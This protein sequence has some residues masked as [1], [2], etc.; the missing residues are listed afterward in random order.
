MNL[1]LIRLVSFVFIL[2]IVFV[3]SSFGTLDSE[4]VLKDRQKFNKLK[5]TTQNIYKVTMRSGVAFRL[6]TALGYVSTIDLPERA[7]KVY[8]GD[9]ELYK[10]EV[11]ERQVLVKPITDEEDARTNLIIVTESGRL[12]FDVSVGSP[13]TADFVLDFRLPIDD[14]Y[15]VR[16][17]FDE[18]VQEKVL[19]LESSYQEQKKELDKKAE[20][21]S[22]QKLKERVASG[23]QSLNLKESVSAGDVQLN[24]L[25]LSRVAD[26]GYLRFS[27]LNYSRTPYRVLR[28][29]VGI[30][31]YEKKF[32]RSKES[33]FIE[34][35]SELELPDVIPPDSYEYGVAVFDFRVLGKKEKPVFKVIEDSA[36][37]SESRDFKVKGF[38]WFK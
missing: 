37:G 23:V 38:K 21:I 31:T 10:V 2:N 34:L 11:Y 22:K 7:L 1:F 14:E 24:L 36:A 19:E 9:Q 18:K 15:L 8:V 26:K 29:S 32:L 20:E 13:Q 3:G 6:Q 25:S 4:G 12:V 27:I 33:G 17:A 5:R 28:T 35:S 16:N 30:L